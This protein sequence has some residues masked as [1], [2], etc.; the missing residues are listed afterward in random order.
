MGRESDFEKNMKWIVVGVAGVCVFCQLILLFSEFSIYSGVGI[1]F[2]SL[3]HLISLVGAALIIF[4]L[5]KQVD[6]KEVY[7]NYIFAAMSISSIFLEIYLLFLY[8]I[9]S[10]KNN[11]L[12]VGILILLFVL[13][14]LEVYITILF[15]RYGL[16]KITCVLP[17]IIAIVLVIIRGCAFGG[18]DSSFN[19]MSTKVLNDSIFSIWAFMYLFFYLVLIVGTIVYLDFGFLDELIHNP[20]NLFSRNTLYGTYTNLYLNDDNESVNRVQVND[21]NMQS[22]VQPVQSVQSSQP[23]QS[24]QSYQPV[25][26]DRIERKIIGKCPDCGNDIYSDQEICGFCGCPVSATSN[27]VSVSTVPQTQSENTVEEKQELI[28]PE[29]GSVVNAE[30]EYCPNCGCPKSEF[31]IKP[32]II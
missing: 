9:K 4:I 13:I 11:C 20:K 27:S 26:P 12:N 14:M 21:N 8:L 28:C 17:M 6:D 23:I 19:K 31:V 1:L 29:C 10:L 7:I 3:N 5:I 32:K 22:L 15:V 25:Q 24:E 2:N 16:D 30:A 18:L